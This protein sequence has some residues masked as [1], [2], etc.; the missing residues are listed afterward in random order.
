M[1]RRVALDSN[2]LLYAELEP[3]SVKG[4]RAT[5]I[6]GAVAS[7]GV[8]P[9]QAIGEFLAVVRRRRPDALAEALRQAEAYREVFIVVPTEADILLAAADFA[10]RYQLQYWDAVIWQAAMRGGAA[11]LL[12]EDMQDGFAV[13]GLRIV[14]PF[15]DDWRAIIGLPAT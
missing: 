11:I 9:A 1:V 3:D 15:G 2:V 8:L 6:I 14:D 5:E 12:S 4:Q 7:R 10:Q 13:G